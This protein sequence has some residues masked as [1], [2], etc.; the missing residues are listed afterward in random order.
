MR[1]VLITAA[2]VLALAGCADEPAQGACP[3]SPTTE[4]SKP[5]LG[6]NWDLFVNQLHEIF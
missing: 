1:W 3:P 6:Q 4:L 2:F 5:T